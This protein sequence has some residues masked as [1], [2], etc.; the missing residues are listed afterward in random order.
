M[1]KNQNQNQTLPV[2]LELEYDSPHKLDFIQKTVF[3]IKHSSRKKFPFTIEIYTQDKNENKGY[4]FL[5]SEI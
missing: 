4:I 3:L 2:F 5:T 1:I